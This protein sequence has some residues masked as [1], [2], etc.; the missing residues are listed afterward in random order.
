MEDNTKLIEP[1]LDRI[2]DYGNT[3]YELI[4]LKALDKTS[5]IVSSFIPHSVVVTLISTFLIFMNFG[6]AFWIGNLLGEIYYGF[7]IIAGFYGVTGLF[8]N[9]F[10]HKW[11]K[12]RIR[13]F[14]IRIMLK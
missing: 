14:V 12:E 4:K 2:T 7:F 5:D 6:F 8:V 1:L 13:N 9:L 11:L 10:M 3:S